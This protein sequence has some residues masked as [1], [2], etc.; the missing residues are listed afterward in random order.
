MPVLKSEALSIL[1]IITL[2]I[3]HKLYAQIVLY[4][5]L[6]CEALRFQYRQQIFSNYALKE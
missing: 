1:N 5:T 6:N 4:F 3:K 2:V